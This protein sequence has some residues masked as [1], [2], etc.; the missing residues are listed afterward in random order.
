MSDYIVFEQNGCKIEAYQSVLLSITSDRMPGCRFWYSEGYAEEPMAKIAAKF[1]EDSS[2]AA[3]ARDAALVITY[4]D[5]NVEYIVDAQTPS[6]KSAHIG[7]TIGR[8]AAAHDVPHD[9]VME[10][11]LH[12]HQALENKCR[13]SRLA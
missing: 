1:G 8:Y 10:L 11:L 5:G 6:T 13:L 7:Y 12:M 3:D 2:Q 9:R 4:D